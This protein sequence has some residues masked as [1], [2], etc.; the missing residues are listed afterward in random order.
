MSGR[1]SAGNEGYV[2]AGARRARGGFR[3]AAAPVKLPGLECRD[4]ARRAAGPFHIDLFDHDVAKQA[5]G[6]GETP[7][8]LVHGHL[9][10]ERCGT[11]SALALRW[12]TIA[13]TLCSIC[14]LS[15]TLRRSGEPT[16]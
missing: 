11:A 10:I 8:S 14:A 5:A 9:I 12:A 3:C 2:T 1:G 13:S 15:G 16:A 7:V 4:H 6:G